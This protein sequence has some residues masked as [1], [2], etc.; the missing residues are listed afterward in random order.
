MGHWSCPCFSCGIMTLNNWGIEVVSQP[1]SSSI[2]SVYDEVGECQAGRYRCG[3]IFFL[4][5]TACNIL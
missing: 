2:P 3:A 5:N 1:T 4:S